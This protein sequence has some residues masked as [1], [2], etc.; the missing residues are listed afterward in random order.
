VDRGEGR[1]C[2][3]RGEGRGEKGRERG[4]G[5]GEKGEGGGER[6]EGEKERR[7]EGERGRKNTRVTDHFQEFREA[8][9]KYNDLFISLGLFMIM[10]R[11]RIICWRNFL[12]KVHTM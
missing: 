4:E 2:D 12:K 6:G 10:E 1:G 8:L 9:N 3:G 5:R 11:L 7:G